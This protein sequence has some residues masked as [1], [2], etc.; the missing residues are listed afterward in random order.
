MF[1]GWFFRCDGVTEQA[2]GPRR[3]ALPERRGD[4]SSWSQEAPHQA[5]SLPGQSSLPARGTSVVRSLCSRSL[6]MSWPGSELL[7][8]GSHAELRGASQR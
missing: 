5:R 7:C 1:A 8:R 6:G 2:R 4:P 3:R